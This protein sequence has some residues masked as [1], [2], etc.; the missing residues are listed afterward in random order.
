MYVNSLKDV[1]TPPNFCLPHCPFFPLPHF[2]ESR[3]RWDT[4]FAWVVK[5]LAPRTGWPAVSAG[6]FWQFACSGRGSTIVFSR[7]SWGK[8]LLMSQRF[9]FFFHSFFLT[10]KRN[11]RSL[12]MV[13]T[14][15]FG[16]LVWCIIRVDCLP[17][18]ELSCGTEWVS[19]ARTYG[20][21]HFDKR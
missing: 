19:R 6:I 9:S 12:S 20:E 13:M 1:W 17:A 15:L 7:L 14:W 3:T 18:I 5:R 11:N 2:L 10:Q 21:Q 16:R 4:S 8:Y